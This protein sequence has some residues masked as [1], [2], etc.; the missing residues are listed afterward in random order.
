MDMKY[1]ALF[2]WIFSLLPCFGELPPSVYLDLQ[3]KSP[4]KI[5]I[6]VDGVK[7]QNLFRRQEIVSA[8]VMKVIQSASFLKVGDK[9]EIRYRHVSLK[10]AAGPSPIP[11]L[12]RGESYPAWLKKGQD[13]IYVP[14]S[15]GKSFSQVK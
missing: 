14:F 11:R 1:P 7:H 2:L 5:E 12:K 15:R 4:E 8:T 10:G 6:R 9:I 3:K 13:G